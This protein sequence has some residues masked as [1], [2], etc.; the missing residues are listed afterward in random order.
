MAAEHSDPPIALILRR[1][2]YMYIVLVHET[3]KRKIK[4]MSGQ[5]RSVKKSG[6]VGVGGVISLAT[7]HW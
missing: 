1:F 4:R 3:S 7:G 5:S 2:V 6:W